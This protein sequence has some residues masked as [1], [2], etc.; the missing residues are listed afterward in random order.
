MSLTTEMQEKIYQSLDDGYSQVKFFQDQVVMLDGEKS[1][2]DN[3]I[4]KL[5]GE[6]FGE[7]QI[8]NRAIDD[9]KDAYSVRFAGVTSCRSDLFWMVTNWNDSPTPNLYTFKSCSIESKW[10]YGLK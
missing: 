10:I 2:W 6:L 5:D 4:S 3:A 8:V 7:I 9:V 1:T